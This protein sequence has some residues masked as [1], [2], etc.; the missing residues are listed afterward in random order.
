[1]G[2]PGDK[3][4][5]GH[6]VKVEIVI[7]RVDP[8]NFPEHIDDWTDSVG[9]VLGMIQ[10]PV[11]EVFRPHPDFGVGYTGDTRFELG[12]TAAVMEEN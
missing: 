4:I 2:E 3:F 7:V 6:P 12:V 10:T 8:A 1:M 5:T 9:T 11:R